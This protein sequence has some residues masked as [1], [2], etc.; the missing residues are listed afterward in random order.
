MPVEKRVPYRSSFYGDWHR[1]TLP[2]YCRM[3]DADWFEV[4][5]ETIVACI[6][7]IVIPQMFIDEAQKIYPIFSQE[8]WK[9][10]ALVLKEIHKKMNLPVLIVRH[11]SDCKR[12]AL[13]YVTPSGDETEQQVMTEEAFQHVLVSLRHR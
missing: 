4:R 3:S 7:T 5:D 6:E 10:K 12:F 2:K 8:D 13:S 9:T 1:R 11:T